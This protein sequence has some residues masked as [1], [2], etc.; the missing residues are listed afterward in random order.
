MT[1]ILGCLSDAETESSI[2]CIR[3]NSVVEHSSRNLQAV[4]ETN[5]GQDEEIEASL[6]FRS[7]IKSFKLMI[8]S[9][10]LM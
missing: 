10:L 1:S 7:L 4:G 8:S 6:V 9:H 2:E 3:F 5:D